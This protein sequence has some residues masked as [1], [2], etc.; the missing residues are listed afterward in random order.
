V[1][2][3]RT[4]CGLA[5]RLPIAPRRG[6]DRTNR[7]QLCDPVSDQ[8]KIASELWSGFRGSSR[9][10]ADD[11]RRGAADAFVA[12]AAVVLGRVQDEVVS[13]TQRLEQNTWGREKGTYSDG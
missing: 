12:D 8:Q 13:G 5:N 7:R 11:A 10:R 4:G 1:R 6:W 3:L 2:L 9:W